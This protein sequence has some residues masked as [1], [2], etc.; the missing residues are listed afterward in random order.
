MKVRL[1]KAGL[2]AVLL[3]SV[4]GCSEPAT[5]T[6]TDAATAV[7]ASHNVV[8]ASADTTAQAKPSSADDATRGNET[9]AEASVS[10]CAHGQGTVY[11]ALQGTDRETALTSLRAAEAACRGA[12]KQVRALP[13]PDLSSK[14][15]SLDKMADGLGKVGDAMETLDR[16]PAEARAM[17]QSGMATYKE[18][19]DGFKSKSA[20]N[21]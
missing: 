8:T 19:L 4:C 10:A 16:S 9:P 2:A 7:P 5:S 20:S 14:A 3:A 11:D 6:G 13:D 1:V 21:D 18:G 17:A 12:A 15:N